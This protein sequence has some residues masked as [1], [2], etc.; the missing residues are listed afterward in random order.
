[1]KGFRVPCLV[2]LVCN[3]LLLV[4]VLMLSFFKLTDINQNLVIDVTGF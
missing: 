3:L 2:I 4:T 1:M